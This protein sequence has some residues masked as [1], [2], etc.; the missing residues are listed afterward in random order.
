MANLQAT[1]IPDADAEVYRIGLRQDPEALEII[2]AGSK[3]AMFDLREQPPVFGS[4]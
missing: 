4:A 3:E 2:R 1:V